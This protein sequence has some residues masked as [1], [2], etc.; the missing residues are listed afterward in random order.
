MIAG[1]MALINKTYIDVADAKRIIDEF[2]ATYYP[3]AIRRSLHP[4]HA[5][6]D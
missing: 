3:S 6:D 5:L 2:F 4:N 1:N